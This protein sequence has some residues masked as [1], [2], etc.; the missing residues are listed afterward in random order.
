MNAENTS[1]ILQ[2]SNN[3]AHA[4]VKFIFSLYYNV[5]VRTQNFVKEG[6]RNTNLVLKKKKKPNI[7]KSFTLYYRSS[8]QRRAGK[9]KLPT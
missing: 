2:V 9:G 3:F 7:F 1:F 4:R 5:H 8:A 6:G